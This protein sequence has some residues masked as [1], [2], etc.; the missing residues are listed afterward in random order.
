MTAARRSA[1]PGHGARRRAPATA[2][3]VLLALLGLAVLGGCASIPTSGPVVDGK[4]EPAPP[5]PIYLNPNPP[6]DDASPEQ[7]VNGFLSAQGPGTTSSYD[8]ARAY[9]TGSAT[10]WDPTARVTVYR[11]DAG[12]VVPDDADDTG[13]TTVTG[14]VSVVGTIDADGVYTEVSDGTTQDLSFG[15]VQDPDGR[16]RIDDAED[17]LFIQS[18]L[19]DVFYQQTTLYFPTPDRTYFVSDERWFPKSARW[20]TDAV[21]A[22]LDGPAEWLQDSVVTVA[23]PG[24]TLALQTVPV[25]DGVATVNLSSAVLSAS[26]ADRALLQAQIQAVIVDSYPRTQAFEPVRSVV[27]SADGTPISVDTVDPLPSAQVSGGAVAASDGRLVAVN[28]STLTKIDGA[29]SLEGLLPTALGLTGDV[30][31]GAA[32]A[33]VLVRDGTAHVRRLPTAGT[34][35]A[36]LLE[37][38]DLMA[39]SAD[40]FGWIWSGSATGP[41]TV[42]DRDGTRTRL[43]AVPWLA[44]RTLVSVRVA[45][46]GARLVVASDG[47]GGPLVQV[48]GIVRDEEGRPTALSDPFRVA[49]STVDVTSVVWTD[50]TQVGVLGRQTGEDDVVVH[51]AQVGGQTTS[52]SRVPGAVAIA[53]GNGESTLLVVDEKGVL[54]GRSESATIWVP[55]ATDVDLVAYPG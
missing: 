26:A 19:L 9:L 35:G 12:L 39:P 54:Y 4:A 48:A 24:T 27:L 11:G 2:L 45:P 15:L 47:T 33:A 22:V 5:L 21:S 51:L 46:D 49:A 38:A 7:I 34:K 13:K 37:G 44:D 53:A 29:P 1:A 31:Q 17:G 3:T 32:G 25:S 14:T 6:R 41:I 52:L 28:G 30:A 10:D 40:R 16:W 42:L 23:P 55:E 50:Q 18:G 8:V 36:T 43:A 20:Q